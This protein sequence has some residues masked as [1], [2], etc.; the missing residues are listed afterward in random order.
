MAQRQ[1]CRCLAYTEGAR[2]CFQNQIKNFKCLSF[3][4]S[5]AKRLHFFGKSLTDVHHLLWILFQKVRTQIGSIL[6]VFMDSNGAVKIQ[7]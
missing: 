4:K 5:Q 1:K 3:E 6:V 7:T 2:Q